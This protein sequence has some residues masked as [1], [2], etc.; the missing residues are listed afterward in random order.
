MCCVEF[1]GVVRVEE[2]V[3]EELVEAFMSVP[4]MLV[5]LVLV[6]IRGLKV[7]DWDDKN[8]VDIETNMDILVVVTTEV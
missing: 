2:C 7:V 5:D 4:W 3:A 6:V 1:V 8:G